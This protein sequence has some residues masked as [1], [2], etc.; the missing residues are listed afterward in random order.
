ML[1]A[2]SD[3]LS[4]DAFRAPRRSTDHAALA[5]DAG[6][7]GH[8]GPRCWAVQLGLPDAEMY[9]REG[10]CGLRPAHWQRCA[11]RRLSALNASV[12]PPP[13]HAPALSPRIP[14]IGPPLPVREPQRLRPPLEL[15]N[16]P[17]PSPQR[18]RVLAEEAC[19]SS[20]AM[21]M[22]AVVRRH[23]RGIGSHDPPSPPGSPRRARQGPCRR[24]VPRAAPTPRGPRSRRGRNGSPRLTPR[25]AAAPLPVK[26]QRSS[27]SP[28][29]SSADPGMGVAKAGAS[30]T[31]P[32]CNAL[33]R[34]MARFVLGP[35]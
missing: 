17:Q 6:P 26:S 3:R 23:P 34:Y 16:R 5:P 15:P 30:P 24:R 12:R 18:L 11:P 31:E 33:F 7:R 28:I 20:P 13:F 19:R 32:H 27:T 22:A 29:S 4:Q 14:T 2:R 9:A 10:S 8:F 21:I 35:T 1:N 25:F